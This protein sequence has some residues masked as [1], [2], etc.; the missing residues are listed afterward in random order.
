MQ[1][2]KPVKRPQAE[3][4]TKK[5]GLY[6]F[7]IGF[8]QDFV[9]P[10]GKKFLLYTDHAIK[11]ANLDG[12][13]SLPQTVTLENGTLIELNYNRQYTRYVYR[14]S[15]SNKD[16]IVMVLSAEKPEFWTVV[17]CWTNSVKDRHS[18]LNKSKYTKP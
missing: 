11:E 1:L 10:T 18:T 8:P 17:T 2:T 6:H 15:Y 7:L 4:Q 13:K 12:I 16:D 9:P 14:F 3:K 5:S